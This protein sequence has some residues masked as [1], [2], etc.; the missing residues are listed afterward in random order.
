MRLLFCIA[1][2]ILIHGG[3]ACLS[4]APRQYAAPAQGYQQYYYGQQGQAPQVAAPYGARAAAAAANRGPTAPLNS[5]SV[6]DGSIV[7]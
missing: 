2:A 4:S 3:F 6:S 7:V 5:G 1:A